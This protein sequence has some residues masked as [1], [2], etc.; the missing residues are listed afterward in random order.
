M[1]SLR[2]PNILPPVVIE[3]AEADVDSHLAAGWLPVTAPEVE[4]PPVDAPNT[5]I[6]ERPRRNR[7]AGS[8][9]PKE[10]AT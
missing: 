1:T 2:H 5:P 9:S 7:R 6:P 8:D 3:V 4:D 10:T